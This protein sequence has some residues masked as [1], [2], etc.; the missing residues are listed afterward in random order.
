MSNLTILGALTIFCAVSF[1]QTE[2][3]PVPTGT[4]DPLFRFTRALANR[5]VDDHQTR[6][7]VAVVVACAGRL[8]E[9]QAKSKEYASSL[10][11]TLTQQLSRAAAAL[12]LLGTDSLGAVRIV[13]VQA[14]QET[15]V[16]KQTGFEYLMSAVAQREGSGQAS[17]KPIQ[18]VVQAAITMLSSIE[19]DAAK[20]QSAQLLLY[21]AGTLVPLFGNDQIALGGLKR[22]MLNLATSTRLE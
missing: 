13:L 11:E 3:V 7:T 10:R 15:N 16:R 12:D 1:G 6:R 21:E 17:G 20:Y 5:R 8:D 14:L 22:D 2:A 9:L 4:A 19:G 18:E